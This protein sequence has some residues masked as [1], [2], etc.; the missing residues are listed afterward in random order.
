M[1]ARSTNRDIFLKSAQKRAF[2]DTLRS[3][4]SQLDQLAPDPD[5]RGRFLA[6]ASS[7]G[8]YTISS[9]FNDCRSYDILKAAFQRDLPRRLS[10]EM[11]IEN[12]GRA[13]A[14]IETDLFAE[15]L[16]LAAA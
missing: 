16:T 14:S 13:L 5:L 9:I 7:F 3:L 1:R 15:G 12:C 11:Q 4:K 2:Q 10:L 6:A 8:L